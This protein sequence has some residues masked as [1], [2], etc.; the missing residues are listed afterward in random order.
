MSP[1]ESQTGLRTFGWLVLGLAAGAGIGFAII[2]LRA[3]LAGWEWDNPPYADQALACTL[4][5]SLVGIVIGAVV[6]ASIR[7]NVRKEKLLAWAWS[8]L[9]VAGVIYGLLRPAFQLVRE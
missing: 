2:D 8:L 1:A 4:I 5:G 3:G 9:A 7:V 6:E